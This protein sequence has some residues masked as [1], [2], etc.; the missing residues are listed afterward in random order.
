MARGDGELRASPLRSED[1]DVGNL[2]S[3]VNQLIN[4]L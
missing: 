2:I 4:G 1:L 3:C